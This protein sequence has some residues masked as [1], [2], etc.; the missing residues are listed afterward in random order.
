[1][2][3]LIPFFSNHF[4]IALVLMLGIHKSLQAEQ[5]DAQ[6]T[7]STVDHHYFIENKGQWPSDVLYLARMGGLDAWITK[8][9]VN[10]T[11][12]KLEEIENTSTD[13]EMHLPKKFEHKDY[14]IIGHRVLMQLQNHNPEPL[15]EGKEKQVGYYNY[16]IGN[17]ES[18]HVSNVGLY[19]QALVKEVY[20]G[21]DLRYYYDKGMLRYDYIV[22]PGANPSQIMFAL[23]GSDKNYVNDKG[24]LVF[25]TRFGEVAMADLYVYQGHD[26]K[27]V[28]SSFIKKGNEAWAF[29]IANYDSTQDLIIDPLIYSTY[30][31]GAIQD[32]GR[33]IA[34]DTFGNAYIAGYTFSYDYDV[35]PGAFQTTNLGGAWI[36]DAFVTKLNTTG[37]ALL[38]STYI[39]GIA[40]DKGSGIAI[41]ASGNAYI[42]GETISIDYVV[43]AGAFQSTL[44]GGQYEDVFVTKLNPSGT[45]ILYSTYIGG[46]TNDYGYGIA[47]DTDGNAYITGSAGLDY[48]VT[49]GAFQTTYAGVMPFSDAFVTKLNPTGTALL[50]STYIGGSGVEWAQ[51]IAIDTSGNAYITGYTKSL[52]Y[53]VTPGAFQTTNGAPFGGWYDVFVTKLNATGTALLYSTYIGGSFDD[54]SNDIAIDASGNAYITGNS[55]SNNYPVTPGAFQTIHSAFAVIVTKLNATGTALLYSTFLGGGGFDMGYSIAV[56]T[57]RNAYITGTAGFN[58][59]VTAG[60]FQTIPQGIYNVILTKLNPTGTALYYSTYIG[61]NSQ[62][63]GYDMALDAIGNV[64]ITGTTSSTDYDVSPGAFQTTLDGDFNAFVTKL[65]IMHLSS[66]TGTDSQI[67][68]INNPITN[69]I[70]SATAA[71]SATITGLPAGVIGNFAGGIVTISGTPT[72]IG[73]FNYT[74]TFTGIGAYP[75]V[76]G[77]ITVNPVNS[78]NLSSTLVTVNQTVFVNNAITNITYSAIGATGV[79]VLG[80]PPGVIGNFAGGVVT[81]SGTPTITGTFNYIV[82][83][84]GGCGNT[85][86]AGSITVIA[87]VGIEEYN[88][89]NSWAFYPNPATNQITIQGKQGSVFEWLD[90]QGRLLQTITLREKEKNIPVN[91]PRGLYF[92]RE[93]KSGSVKKIL[94]E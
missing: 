85:T 61:G 74:I 63:F 94:V 81:I 50:Y 48:D 16:F 10:Y 24:N 18:K 52:D 20:Q 35:T 1:M 23:K 11:F 21:I 82:S 56:D 91:Y 68:C 88:F 66:A 31:G 80:L 83:L 7:L 27:A 72:N 28:P 19:K 32:H 76:T 17:D 64:Y 54:Y 30:I 90:V 78:L 14:N 39:G 93:Q 41:D 75:S 58:Y 79:T 25:T 34:I 73:I 60:A 62:N 59:N 86:A 84:S 29:A 65:S 43:S 77:I 42:T 22:H 45:A 51:D 53:D 37:S 4:V 6:Q 44:G 55:E 57:S 26:N 8:Y 67:V 71:S 47:L 3:T 87:A 2:K 15:K 92:I 38:Y 69:I 49:A 9:G 40:N 12:I 70:Y 5:T 46:S 89:S 36:S 13:R 33:S